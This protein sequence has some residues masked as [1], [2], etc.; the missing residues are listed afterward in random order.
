MHAPKFYVGKKVTDKSSIPDYCRMVH[1]LCRP[2]L[3]YNDKREIL[4]LRGEHIEKQNA[5][6][7]VIFVRPICDVSDYM[8]CYI[9]KY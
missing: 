4:N 8:P 9:D 2:R 5:C 1:E 6:K 7:C 3:K